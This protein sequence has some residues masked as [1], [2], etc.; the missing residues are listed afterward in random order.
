MA[1]GTQSPAAQQTTDHGHAAAQGMMKTAADIVAKMHGA[2]SQSLAQTQA[3]QGGTSNDD[4][5]AAITGGQGQGDPSQGGSQFPSLDPGT[6]QQAIQSADPHAMEAYMHLA[7]QDEDQM[8]QMHN[9][10]IDQMIAS[11]AAPQ[12][13]PSQQPAMSPPGVGGEQ[14]GY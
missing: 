9:Q 1:A 14:V 10:I 11:L 4:L 12:G 13:D 8:R 6:Q 7:Q 3:A 2:A 5:L